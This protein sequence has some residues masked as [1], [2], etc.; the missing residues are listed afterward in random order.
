ML[1]VTA[2]ALVACVMAVLTLAACASDE[3]E[4]ILSAAAVAPD[5]SSTAQSVDGGLV[6]EIPE[7]AVSGEGRVQI[8]ASADA[9]GLPGWTV[10]LSGTRLVGD[11]VLR[12]RW[13][14]TQP[15]EPLPM[16]T[17]ADTATVDGSPVGGVTRDG[18]FLVVRTDHFSFWQI[19]PW[20]A[21]LEQA[22][23]W[24]ADTLDRLLSAA[25]EGRAPT[26][27][28]EAAVREEG[29]GITS[30]SGRRVYWCVGE[31][32]DKV[33]LKLVNARGYGV[34]AESTPG[35]ALTSKATDDVVASIARL[36]QAP[37]SKAD[38]TV[39]LLGSG[40]EATY[41]VS[42]EQPVGVMVTPDAGAYLLSALMFGID[43]YTWVAGNVGVQ[44]A[45]QK[46][47][48]ALE[49]LSCM[50]SFM[51]MATTELTSAAAARDFFG[52]ALEMSFSC[53]A[54]AAGK[55]DLGV[56]NR[57]VVQPL[58]W[59]MTG[60]STAANGLVAAIDSAMDWSGYQVVITPPMPT[61]SPTVSTDCGAE[62]FGLNVAGLT[63]PAAD[64]ARQIYD[65]AVACDKAALVQIARQDD[66][67]LSLGL[68]SPE[69]AFA[70]PS[71]ENRY[72]LITR[73]MSL[74]PGVHGDT[75]FWPWAD[76][77]TGRPD[78]DE[79]EASGL[80]GPGARAGFEEIGLYMGWRMTISPQGDWIWFAEGE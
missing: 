14:P 38:N 30:D 59:V 73:L 68:T 22:K 26:C 67:E 78:F 12:F 65:A 46:L 43:T 36:I 77:E 50:N 61:R 27:E 40:A 21:V 11:A 51:G 34:S 60:L 79:L 31:E 29:Y 41:E 76:E 24:V 45:E 52:K 53:V 63:G 6:V 54:L 74:R 72:W 49:G 23:A 1:A 66:T 58:V 71:P 33:V 55:V 80:V 3:P 56:I 20:E 25:G 17:Q 39:S 5:R 9:A 57:V 37:P 13:S 70:I 18:E 2:R 62:D 42:G 4:A 15:G 48:A 7:G 8:D 64:R 75:L 69:E 47:L 44:G 32:D 10:T 35:L 19:R 16:I 28:N